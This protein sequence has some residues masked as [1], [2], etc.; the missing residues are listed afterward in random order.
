MYIYNIYIH[1]RIQATLAFL[2]NFFPKRFNFTDIFL[3]PLRMR[4]PPS[5]VGS[6]TR[7]NQ[8]SLC[9]LYNIVNIINLFLPAIDVF[10]FKFCY[11]SQS[12]SITRGYH[13]QKTLTFDHYISIM[14]YLHFW[15]SNFHD[16][17]P[18]KRR[19]KLFIIL[20][21][22]SQCF[23]LLDLKSLPQNPASS[24]TPPDLRPPNSRAA[25]ISAAIFEAG[26]TMAAGSCLKEPDLATPWRTLS[27]GSWQCG[28]LLPG[29]IKEPFRKNWDTDIDVGSRLRF[30][31]DLGDEPTLSNADKMGMNQQFHGV[32][33]AIMRAYGDIHKLLM[34][35]IEGINQ[36]GDNVNLRTNKPWLI[37]YG[38]GSAKKWKLLCI[39]MAPQLKQPRNLFEGLH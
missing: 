34:W 9:I 39:K 33:F 36:H 31:P 32:V 25:A 28:D 22:K 3:H 27:P 37:N 1:I 30:L 11:C 6:G 5:K 15:S 23:I 16:G 19:K 38:N 2:I 17:N 20:L 13:H 35:S 14:V 24:Q 18:R 10:P 8:N 7:P 21:A 4:T 26:G 12:C 29:H